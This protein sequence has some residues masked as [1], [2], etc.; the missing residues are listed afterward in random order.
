MVLQF[1][2]IPLGAQE[3]LKEAIAEILAV[4][5]ESGLPYQLNAMSTLLEG[6]WDDVMGVV[7]RCHETMR[8]R[9][10]RVLTSITVD[11]REGATGRI[12]G[13]VRDV[14][15]VLGRQLRK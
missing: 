12:E 2:V 15:E 6:D 14:E 7:R 10:P 8:A 1:S 13:K 3:E 4:I 9:F 11:D 5:D